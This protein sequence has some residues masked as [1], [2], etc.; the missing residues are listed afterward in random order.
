[1]KDLKKLFWKVLAEKKIASISRWA[2]VVSICEK[3]LKNDFWVEKK[4]EWKIENNI[5]ILKINNSTLSNIFFLHKKK[6]V[7]KI[8]QQLTNMNLEQIKDIK[9]F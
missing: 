6:V 4:L 9:F 3:I 8:N 5:L 7:D 1:M 2:M